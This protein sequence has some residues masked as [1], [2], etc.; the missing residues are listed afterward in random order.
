M[1][2]KNNL[3]RSKPVKRFALANGAASVN[4]PVPTNK[5]APVCGSTSERRF[6]AECAC[7][8][9]GP[10]SSH[11]PVLSRCFG[12]LLAV[13]GLLVVALLLSVS[14]T[15]TFAA[16]PE[17]D[18]DQSCT[19][20]KNAGSYAYWYPYLQRWA[21]SDLPVTYYINQNGASLCT[22]NE[23]NAV[24]R[25]LTNWENVLTAYWAGCYG[26]VTDKDSG[27]YPEPV[28]KDGFNV[29]SWEDMGNAAPLTYGLAHWWWDAQNYNYECDITFN[30]NAAVPWSALR[31]DSCLRGKYDLESV[32][33]HEFGHWM[34]FGHS[35]DT[36]ATM[37]CFSDS[38]ETHKRTLNECDVSAM[39]WRY[40]QSSGAPKPQPGCWP[41]LFDDH[42][43]SNPALGDINR[44]GVE[45]VV[46]ATYDSTLHVLDGRGKELD[47]WPQK[48]GA[49]I[50]GSSP[51]LGD[52]D[53]DGW[54]EIAIGAD[55]DSLYVFK[56]NGA[57]A[58]NWPRAAGS[59]VSTTPSIADLNKDGFV[60]IVCVTDSVYAWRGSDAS[61]LTGWPVY[62]GGLVSR[63]A[64]ALADL[65]GDD[66]LEVVVPG[67]NHKIYAFKP[68]GASLTGWPASLSRTPDEAVAIGDID[69]DGSYEVVSTAKYD[70]VYAWN[71][72]GSRCAGWPVYVTAT[73]GYSAP[74][75]GNLDADAA[76][77]VV[78]GSDSDTLFAFNGD[79]TKL[80]AGWPVRVEGKVRGSAVI[81]DVDG[82]NAY[83]VVAATDQG[84]I[85]AVNGDGTWVSGWPVQFGALADRAPA[86]G[87]IDGNNKLDL[88]VADAASQE[89]FAF[90]LGTVP[91][92]ARY[93]WRMY[94]HDWNRTSCYGF[95]PTAPTTWLFSDAIVDFGYWE[96]FGAGGA[97]IDLSTYSMSSPYSMGVSGSSAPGA[98]ASAYSEL[99][100]ADFSRPYSVKF[101]FA[102]S[103]FYEAN[104]LVFG[105]ARL[106]LMNQD[107]PV[108]VDI[109]GDWSNLVP[110]GP[111][112]GAP[113]P[114]YAY[115]DFEIKVDPTVRTIELLVFGASMGVVQYNTTVVPSD[116]IWLEDR[117]Y[118]GAFL[119]GWYDDFEVH[120]FLPVVAVQPETPSTPPLA[121]V[122]YQS[123]PN[124][125]NPMA[126]IKYSVKES[127]KVVIKIY[128][129]TGRV[130]KGL[131]NEEK[132]ASPTAYSIPWNGT[133]DSG[134]RV[135]SGV[136]FCRME[137]KNFIS[138]KKIVLL[139]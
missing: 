12:V 7:T 83:E 135:A 51:A 53:G 2:L 50:S 66:S 95:T 122:L 13:T 112:F 4:I 74:S 11:A 38:N 126:T 40:P 63:A 26:G 117:E 94:A 130:V 23:F 25:A 93:E 119:T 111:P 45:E 48:V 97:G 129:V 34:S 101:W 107:S 8:W 32:A 31:A 136:Y 67:G 108:M 81:A 27:A 76:L 104:W 54:L 139:R 73:V 137:A 47:H 138:A 124:P 16:C 60:D 61:K 100:N 116:R 65:N 5:S 85:Y 28:Q 128:D 15:A 90:T 69:G 55:N 70:S 91:T 36:K 80:A 68:H 127:G 71:A 113:T 29:V 82:D 58:A 110:L 103:D 57:R 98:F 41:V 99:I 10:A 33:T 52:V 46:F 49:E 118:P 30:D 105:H 102:Y 106:R 1:K 120:G 84:N 17:G 114:P 131:V 62:A 109:A 121:N 22:G 125:M 87:D 75:L 92:E 18:C 3:N 14:P 59:G 88:V 79:G 72:N 37:Y 89:M 132:Q 24:Q 123:Y 21:D 44:D 35:C 20:W 39:H 96:R 9:P 86:I 78:F 19:I 6:L 56:H 77:E 115:A 134:H 64:P 42:V 43:S 133:D